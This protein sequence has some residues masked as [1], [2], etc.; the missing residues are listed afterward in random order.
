M[1]PIVFGKR[2]AIEKDIDSKTSVTSSQVPSSAVNLIFD[3]TGNFLIYGAMTGIKVINT[4]TNKCVRTIG[5]D[6]NIRAAHLAIYQGAPKRKDV[7]TVE[8]AAS[9]NPLLEEAQERDP[10]I[11]CTAWGSNRFYMFT[12]EKEYV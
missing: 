10:M 6:E 9:S 1:D 7:L 4:V 3:E 12:N 5:A 8:M 2:L 11:V